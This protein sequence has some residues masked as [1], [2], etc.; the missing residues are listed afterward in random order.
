MLLAHDLR[1]I[2]V[3]SLNAKALTRKALVL[4]RSCSWRAYLICTL[5]A[6]NS[7]RSFC[8]RWIRHPARD[9]ESVSVHQSC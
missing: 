7:A 8:S 2:H 6:Q 4:A 3:C 5:R 1:V 9:V